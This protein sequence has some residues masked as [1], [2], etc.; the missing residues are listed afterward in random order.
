M[1]KVKMRDNEDLE[2]LIRRFRKQVMKEETIYECRKHDFFL[3]KALKRKEKSKHARIK[4][5]K[6]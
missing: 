1:A 4:S 2:S 3:K 6:K 5:R